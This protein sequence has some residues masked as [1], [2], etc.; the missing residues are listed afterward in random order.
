MSRDARRP[1][2]GKQEASKNGAANKKQ[3]GRQPG[4]K[5]TQ[6][7]KQADR[8]PRNETSGRDAS[9]ANDTSSAKDLAKDKA[10]EAKEGVK[11]E[12]KAKL[13]PKTA[14]ANATG[15]DYSDKNLKDQLEHQGADLAMDATPG[16]AQFNQARK[17]LKEANKQKAAMGGGDDG[18]SN[19]VEEKMDDAVE[20][21]IKAV[22]IAGATAAGGT[23]AG[24]SI[25]AIL[26]MKMLL[27]L[28]GFIMGLASKAVGFLAG[29]F[30]TVATAIT[31]VLGVTGT[32]ANALASGLIAL[33][34]SVASLAG[35]GGVQLVTL[36]D[37]GSLCLPE[38]KTVPKA[39]QTYV[40]DG[41]EAAVMREENAKKLWSVF[42]A[43]GGTKEQTAAVLGNLHHES[44]GLD[45][46][47]TET[48]FD[49]GFQ[50]GPRKQ[51]AML[52]D[53]D[54]MKIDAAY[55]TKYP[56][57][58]YVGIGLAQ[59]TNDRNRLLISYAKDKKANW[60]EFDTQVSFMLAGDDP[61]RQTQLKEFVGGSKGN[62]TQETERF[63]NT[64]IGLSSPNSSLSDR[65]N[66]ATDYVFMLERATADTSY[67]DGI[68]SG[69]NVSRSEGNAS[70]DAFFADDGCGQNI[71]SHY[72]ADKAEDGTGEVPEGIELTPWTRESLPE[73]LRKYA[74]DPQEAGVSWG[75][76]SGWAPGVIADQCVA[77][78]TSLFMKLYPDWNKDGRGT[79]RPTGNGI[80]TAS[81]WAS[82]YGQSTSKSPSSGAVF[83]L[84][85]PSP[86]GHTG[87]VSHVFSNGDILVV[88]QNIRGVSGE[89]AGMSHS[90]SYRV[91][92]KASYQ[93]D[94][95][96]FFKPTGAT[97]Q[98]QT[99]G[100]DV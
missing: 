29:I 67:A 31:N 43:M 44:S 84:P 55:G 94:G 4:G 60:Y 68:L 97:P 77:L 49:E 35:Y 69:A 82:H 15:V 40:T 3:A 95:W 45:P 16:L 19:K 6:D 32:I 53:Y 81:G 98:W 51:Q 79:S 7:K 21:G 47:A 25:A 26:A 75:N 10:R 91:I 62:V 23:V 42:S 33:A 90:W 41:G 37:T 56:A 22:K 76:A 36:K 65:Q 72:G 89:G 54:V 92:T 8:Q 57:I 93:A 80:G 63:M 28:K 27:F 78:A 34:V 70:A 14:A 59:W 87:I 74:R 2:G 100:G 20:G 86:Y 5:D 88:E 46:T 24:G 66:S 71:A 73:G 52:A 9:K 99:T 12:A 17:K 50:M 39:T 13:N 48:I 96:S 11:D 83:S 30:N 85:A 64:W 58:K 38:Q 1:G 61:T 18:L